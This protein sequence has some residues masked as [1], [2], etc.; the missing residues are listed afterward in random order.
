MCILDGVSTSTWASW[1]VSALSK[2]AGGRHAVVY[3]W[4][5]K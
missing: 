2:R 3:G 5:R 4:M 1:A